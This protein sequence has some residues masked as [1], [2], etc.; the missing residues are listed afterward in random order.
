MNLTE[1]LP[2]E[3]ARLSLRLLHPT[4]AAEVQQ[5]TDHPV[6]TD[7]IHFLPQPFTIADAARMIRGAGDG[8]DCFVGA[9]CRNGELVA[10][11]G[12]HLH[13]EHEVEI[14]YWVRADRHGQG[15]ATEAASAI[16]GALRQ[17]FPHRQVVAECRAENSASWHV[18]EKLG[19]RASGEKGQRP[20]RLRLILA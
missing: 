16:V 13:G 2:I 3:T 17:A 18:L 6:I 19:F 8:R 5:M 1:V 15:Y 9:W 20:G 7:L 4:D 11:V 10:I 12:T 14:G